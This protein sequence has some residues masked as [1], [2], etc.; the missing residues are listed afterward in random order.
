[1]GTIFWL[2]VVGIH[3]AICPH[4]HQNPTMTRTYIFRFSAYLIVLIMINTII[5]PYPAEYTIF[6]IDGGL[7]CDGIVVAG[8]LNGILL[9]VLGFWY[10]NSQNIKTNKAIFFGFIVITLCTLSAFLYW[11]YLGIRC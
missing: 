3:L 10:L 7:N 2:L 8:F 5:T 9:P 1:M 11:C 6:G 4:L